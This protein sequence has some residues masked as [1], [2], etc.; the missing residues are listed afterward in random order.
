MLSVDRES[1]PADTIL[2]YSAV[3]HLA[4]A[5]FPFS[6]KGKLMLM[7]TGYFDE[8]G[9]SQDPVCQV[10]GMAGFVAPAAHWEVFE[11]E[12]KNALTN[13]GLE[14]AFHM[15]EFAHSTGQFASWKGKEDQRRMLMKC[16]IKIIQDTQAMPIGVVV[17]LEAFKSLT[18]EQQAGFKD[19]Y[20]LAFQHCTRGASTEGMYELS[21]DERVAMVY[22]LN[23]EFGTE[24]GLAEQLWHFVKRHYDYGWRLGT[25]ASATPEDLCPLQAADLF[26]YELCHEFENRIKRPDHRMRWPLRTIIR[27]SEIPFPKIRLFDRMELLRQIKEA[28][29]PDQTGVD[30][31][32]EEQINRHKASM[33]A[34]MIERGE[35]DGEFPEW[36]EWDEWKRENRDE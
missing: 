25:Y 11:T 2:R 3:R 5:I 29:F 4:S 6:S 35:W 8:S 9:H 23:S 17:S 18:E 28:D 30:Q 22:A 24:R 10:A 36:S 15:K 19:P 20:Y 26:A 12:W 14:R 1:R 32:D 16:L 13:A 33:M 7:L 21:P 31:V 34:W 27:M